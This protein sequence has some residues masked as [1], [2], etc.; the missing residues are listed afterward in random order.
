MQSTFLQSVATT[1]GG[2]ATLITAFICLAVLWALSIGIVGNWS[3]AFNS[4]SEFRKE[5]R[6]RMVIN[7]I[8]Y[9]IILILFIAFFYRLELIRYFN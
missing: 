4:D 1:S 8:L 2:I 9:T 3:H 6:M 5:K 7:I